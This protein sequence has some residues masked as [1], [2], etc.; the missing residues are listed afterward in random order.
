MA[1]LLLP[2]IRTALGRLPGDATRQTTAVVDLTPARA[3]LSNG[4]DP[5]T[6][7]LWVRALC[8]HQAHW[9]WLLLTTPVNHED[10][11]SLEA[12]HVR[13]HC[14]AAPR[15]VSVTRVRPLPLRILRRILR[16]F[17]RQATPHQPLAVDGTLLRRLQADL[18]FC[19][20]GLT[21]FHDATVPTVALWNDL[22]ALRCSALLPPAERGLPDRILE[23]MLHLA[24]RVVC[25][26]ETVREEILR[27]A[28]EPARRVVALRPQPL[29]HL[30]HQGGDELADALAPLGLVAGNYLY[31][32]ADFIEP[33]NHKLLL[34]A[35][36]IYRTRH[37]E[38]AWKLVCGG[39]TTFLRG[40]LKAAAGR[41]GLDPYVV[42]TE[43][44]TPAE[45]AVLVQGCGAALFAGLEATRVQPLLHALAFSKPLLCSN[46]PDLP[47]GVRASALLFDPRRPA[48]IASALE[49]VTGDPN[50]RYTLVQHSH[51]QG[52]LL[53]GPRDAAAG[54]VEVFREVSSTFRRGSN[55]L[56][57]LHADGWT[58][59]RLAVTCTAASQS[60][61][62]HLTLEAPRWLPWAHQ[63]IRLLK[64]RHT[65]GKTWRLKRGQQLTL[66]RPLPREGGCLE[67]AFDP[68]IDPRALGHEND[69][70][71]LGAVC[72]ACTVTGAAG[73]IVLHA[74]A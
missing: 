14:V 7:R 15:A 13:R 60:R 39:P 1:R 8:Q 35:F 42:F 30:P 26:S 19:P 51:R 12:F 48:D 25:F 27:R 24:D 6:V 50:L 40:E 56:K 5:A 41:M 37:P 54:L 70:R 69:T 74:A 21:G 43:P 36:G 71:L 64:N 47:E 2:L 49:H 23:D 20:F 29:Q 28:G 57:G 22:A 32:H 9:R 52:Q 17:R 53:G 62:L 61:T 65:R 18:L 4:L 59:D 67:F 11:A 3:T 63:K 44:A 33:N 46:V 31:C 73:D 68:P 45:E 10:Y 66:R 58:A 16:A 38:S 34:A 55:A 72:R